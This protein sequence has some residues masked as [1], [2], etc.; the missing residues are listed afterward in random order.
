MLTLKTFTVNP[1]GENCYIL[2]DESLQAVIIDNGAFYKEE[3]E[4]IINYIEE[5]HLLPIRQIL[6]HA[7]FDHIFG[8][9]DLYDFFGVKVDFH[10]ADD[11]LYYD[12]PSQLKTIVGRT[13]PVKSAPKGISLEEGDKI[14]FGSHSIEVI[15]T[16]GHS[17]G[18]VCYYCNDEKIL[19]SGD[20]LFREGMGR[21]DFIGGDQVQ[22][23]HSIK[24]KILKIDEDVVVYPGHG[25]ST[26]IAHEKEFYAVS[27]KR[28]IYR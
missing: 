21:T 7:H 6:T 27:L 2:S 18:G 15:Y 23:I 12:I 24:N 11:Y 13:F 19:F 20:T 8:V 22:L 28:R 17:R 10:I 5:N 25:P 3:K 14:T 16:P 4:A 1:L 26:T 9:A